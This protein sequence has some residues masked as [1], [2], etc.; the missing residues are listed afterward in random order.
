[1]TSKQISD[2]S[3]HSE[4]RDREMMVV[5]VSRTKALESWEEWEL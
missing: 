5:A 4:E 3:Y 2:M 1:M